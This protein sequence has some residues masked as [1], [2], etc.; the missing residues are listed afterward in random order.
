MKLQNIATEFLT[1]AANGEAEQAFAQFVAKDFIHHNP[2]F[3]GDRASLLQAMIDSSQSSP[4]KS[5]EV[6][7]VL[8]DG[9][10][11][12]VH[13]KIVLEQNNTVLSVVHILRFQNQKII[14]FWD[15]VQP[16]SLDSPNE[17]GLF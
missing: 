8:E 10:L 15:V 9:D 14:E 4:N 17:N 1:L 2:H 16:V 6:Q 5:F 12:A 11:V 7:R 13:S 3:K